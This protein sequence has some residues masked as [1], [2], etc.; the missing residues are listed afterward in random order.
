L[1]SR[2]R[3]R[4]RKAVPAAAVLF[5]ALASGSAHAAE[6]SALTNA[7]PRSVIVLVGDSTIFG[8]PPEGGISSYAPSRALE[9][10]LRRLEPRG[11]RWRGASVH[12]VGIPSS[13]TRDWIAAPQSCL[14][15]YHEVWRRGCEQGVGFAYEV[16]PVLPNAS[17]IFVALGVNDDLA[18][19]GASETVDNLEQIV[20]VLAPAR[21]ILSPPFRIVPEEARPE[22]RV[23]RARDAR[24]VEAIR[25]EM[26]D[27]GVLDGVDWPQL[28]TFD[29]LHLTD[30]GYAA[31][32]ALMVDVLHRIGADQPPKEQ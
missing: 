21:V 3:K 25:K 22:I 13:T 12:N 31:A 19:L 11:S 10:L 17:V 32:A 28:P 24:R 7:R 6:R 29:G 4:C 8:T 30:A 2:D 14:F 27:R 16:A 1:G 26:I 23:E 9:I 5:A 15:L 18:A 20:Q